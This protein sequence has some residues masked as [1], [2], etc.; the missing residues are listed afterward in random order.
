MNVQ[1]TLSSHVGDQKNI[2]HRKVKVSYR[3][4]NVF[5]IKVSKEIL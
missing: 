4:V 5:E 2:L 1:N 3:K